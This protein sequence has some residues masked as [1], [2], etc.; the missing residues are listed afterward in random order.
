MDEYLLNNQFGD[1]EIFRSRDRS[2][3]FIPRHGIE[4]RRPPHKINHKAIITALVSQGIDHVLGI[5][6]VGSLRI[7]IEPG[8][9]MIPEDFMQL[10][11]PPTF[12]D[13]DTKHIT[14][15]LNTMMRDEISKIGELHEFPVYKGGV[16]LQTSGPRFETAAEIR[17]FASF[18]DLVG[19]NM[20]SEATLAM[21]KGL[22]YANLSV[23]DNYANGISGHITYGKFMEMVRS[24][25]EKL[26]AFLDILIPGLLK[27]FK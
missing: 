7:D 16:Y 11:A 12:F 21:E 9:F 8:T 25:Q 6:S 27:K 23:V 4:K 15:Q 1:V 14:P 3:V 18:A 20:A 19:M 5:T 13:D 2:L 22:E 17:Y 10:T 26:D 24:H